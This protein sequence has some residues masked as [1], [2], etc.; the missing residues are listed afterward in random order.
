MAVGQVQVNRSL[1]GTLLLRRMAGPLWQRRGQ[2][3]ELEAIRAQLLRERMAGW[4]RAQ[5]RGMAGSETAPVAE[6]RMRRDV[7]AM[8]AVELRRVGNGLA[9]AG[10]RA[11]TAATGGGSAAGSG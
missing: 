6:R 8:S 3:R 4:Q 2:E 7:A 11:A 9:A 1:P 5:A 10:G